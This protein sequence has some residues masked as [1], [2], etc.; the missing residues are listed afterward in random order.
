MSKGEE[1][2]MKSRAG[3]ITIGIAALLLVVAVPL[4]AGAR[5]HRMR[6]E[7]DGFGHGFGMH[8]FGK[9][10]AELNL[11]D[12]Q[13]TQL[14]TI[15]R[16]VHEQNAV[17]RQQMH[18]TMKEAAS[19]LIANPGNVEQA[20]TILQQNDQAHAQ[21]R[22]NILQGVSRGLAVLTPEQRTKLAAYLESHFESHGKRGN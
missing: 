7:G 9:L 12:E 8:I 13:S 22:D 5:G 16:E 4:F 17:Y 14:K 21:L 3:K 10:K 15:A 19:V 2:V 1:R 18:G 20:R 6:G 11:T